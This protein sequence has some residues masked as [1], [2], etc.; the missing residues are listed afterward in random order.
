[1]AKSGYSSTQRSPKVL[2]LLDDKQPNTVDYYRIMQAYDILAAKGYPVAY[3]PY[4]MARR[5]VQ[6]GQLHPEQFDIFVMCRA[7]VGTVDKRLI[8][9]MEMVHE[10]GRKLIYET[11][12]D[13]T[14]VHRRTTEGDAVAVARACDAVTTTTPHLARVLRQHN[15]HVHILPNAI[16]PD[17]WDQVGRHNEDH[18]TIG[19]SGTGTHFEDY[20]LVKDTLFR[21][22]ETY[23]DRVRFLLMG[24][25]PYY[26][27][28]LPNMDFI[29][30]VPYPNYARNLAL[31]DIGLCPL[32]PDDPFNLAKS[33]VKALEYMAAGAAVVAQ[34]MPVYRRVVNQRHN[35]LLAGDHWYEPIAL[36]V[37]DQQ[38]RRKLA[39]QAR[40]WV[41]KHRNIRTLARKWYRVYEEVMRL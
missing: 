34:N 19:L 23:G 29:G 16:N 30:F 15:R 3:I 25:K 27:E 4:G 33:A 38:L 17:I 31:V 35:G 40:A 26:L 12:D 13:Y 6:E 8:Q 37:E 36:L 10:S 24:Y 20:K 41:N 5:L 1:M 22:A 39:K 2:A 9:F 21:L 32:V 28:D 18:I 7:A 11:D 14:N